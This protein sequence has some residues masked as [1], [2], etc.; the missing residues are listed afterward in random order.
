MS[1]VIKENL[2]F[3]RFLLSGKSTK[4]KSLLLKHITKDQLKTLTFIIA[5]I[6][7]SDVPLSKQT[8]EKLK[9]HKKVLRLLGDKTISDKK[10]KQVL[11]AG[12]IVFVLQSV[13]PLLKAV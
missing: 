6:L 10:K 3:L 2:T 1:K 8:F 11:R 4:Q 12:I 5:N 9:K 7:H 13:A